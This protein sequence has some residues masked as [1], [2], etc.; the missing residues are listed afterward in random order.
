MKNFTLLFLSLLFIYACTL[1]VQAQQ[2]RPG[3]LNAEELQ[4]A[5]NPLAS[6]KTLNVHNYA[7][8]SLHGLPDVTMNSLMIRYGQPLGRVFLRASMPFMV[9]STPGESPVTGFGDFSLFAMYTFPKQPKGTYLGFG[10]MLVAPTGSHG[11][12]QEKWQAGLSAVAFF[13]KNPVI[14][15]G[16][17]LQWQISFAD[18][19]KKEATDVSMLTPQIFAMWQLGAGTYLRST[20]VWSFDLESGNYN[21]PLGLG[22]GKV[23][24]AGGTIFNLFGE[25]QFSVLS[26]GIGQSKFQIFIGFNTQF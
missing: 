6:K 17:L 19:D 1:T 10:P 18:T 16:M 20:G 7:I 3:G 9:G 26:K 4:Q 23:V 24:K 11:F 14:Q 2:N 22:I 25:P 8:T 21:I 5:N 13:A 15:Y 12:G